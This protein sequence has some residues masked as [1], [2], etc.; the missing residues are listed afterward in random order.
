MAV[1]IDP[2]L[3]P[4]HG[5]VFSHVI[6]DRSVEELHRFIAGTPVSRRAFDLDHYDVP[7][8]LYDSMVRA[9]AVPVTAGELTRRLRASGLRVPARER[10]AKIRPR[11]LARWERL[12][13]ARPEL[14]RDLLE[15]WEEPHRRYHTSVHLLEVLD[16]LDA[17]HDDDAA[18]AGADAGSGAV[19]ET[20]WAALRLAAWFHD[21]VYQ[22][23]PGQD[24]RDSAE[25]CERMV[26]GLLP[27]HVVRLAVRLILRTAEHVGQD[28]HVGRD[29]TQ[30][31]GP[32]PEAG[33]WAV[34]QDADLGILAAGPH[35]YDRYARAVREE[36]AHL[37]E[38]DFR[39]GRAQVLEG[40][41]ARERLFL[42][43]HGTAR[44]EEPARRNLR[45]E[46]A[47]LTTA[48]Q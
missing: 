11:L 21:A 5:T 23:A 12:L 24:E 46:L 17:L 10:P 19:N 38:E 26:D 1:F 43:E 45:E 22:G 30:E 14:G 18:V 27:E 20:Q 34:F 7:A 40:L 33:A 41:M 15:R 9:G 37:A 16:R 36:Y 44:W 8:A 35:R 3:W 42:T 47:R 39:R 6:S 13:P 25:L 2:P 48:K 32:A 4:A 31:T 28:E 29:E